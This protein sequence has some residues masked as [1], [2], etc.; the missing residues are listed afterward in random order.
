MGDTIAP[1]PALPGARSG[2]LFPSGCGSNIRG[3]FS[4]PRIAPEEQQLI[5]EQRETQRL[6]D[7]E[8]REEIAV[9]DAE[10][11][12]SLLM[13]QQREA[14]RKAQQEA[15]RASQEAEQLAAAEFERVLDMKRSRVGQAEA[16]KSHPDCYEIVVRTPS[17]KRLTRT[18]LN[19]EAVSLLFDW[20]D[21]VAA[22][23]DFTKKDYHLVARSPS[24]PNKELG[25]SSQSLKDAG[26]ERQSMLFVSCCD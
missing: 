11:Q 24:M 1:F 6:I 21:V 8:R 26:L 23:D 14:E 15:E 12:E 10:Y 25:R 18:F 2:S 7:A 16:E 5:E 17:G 3:D 20:I 22:E 9:Q 4:P 13:D 19:T